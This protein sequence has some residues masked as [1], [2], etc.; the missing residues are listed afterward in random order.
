LSLA[1]FDFAISVFAAFDKPAA[2]TSP[3]GTQ[4]NANTINANIKAQAFIGCENRSI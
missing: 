1:P 4:L 2:V 3:Q